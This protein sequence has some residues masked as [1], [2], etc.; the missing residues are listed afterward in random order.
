[1]IWLHDTSTAISALASRSHVVLEVVAR[2]ENP[3]AAAALLE[4]I[5]AL[6][7]HD[8]L[9]VYLYCSLGTALEREAARPPHLHGLVA[10]DHGALATANDVAIDT[11]TASPVDVA[12][13]IAAA[14]ETRA[15]HGRDDLVKVLHQ[16]SGR[17]STQAAARTVR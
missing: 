13:L 6:E 10:R 1:M 2:T 15:R 4:V 8:V 17:S 11:T 12:T 3:S 14:L 16:E 7:A 5:D 9:V